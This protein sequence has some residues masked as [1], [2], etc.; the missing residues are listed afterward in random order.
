[1][2]GVGRNRPSLGFWNFKAPPTSGTLPVTRP[3]LSQQEIH[4]NLSNPYQVVL[5]TGEHAFRYI[6]KQGTLLFK[7]TQEFIKII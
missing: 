2:Q 3:Q 4:S 6:S 5:F 1:M 7:T